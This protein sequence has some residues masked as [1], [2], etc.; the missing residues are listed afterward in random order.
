VNGGWPTAVILNRPSS[1]ETCLKRPTWGGSFGAPTLERGQA[2]KG[3]QGEKC[4]QSPTYRREAV[5]HGKGEAKEPI[6][7]LSWA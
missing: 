2:Q 3:G 6:R 7:Q 4:P 1:E 5:Y